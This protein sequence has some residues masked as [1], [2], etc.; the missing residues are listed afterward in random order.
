MGTATR[1]S[2][3]PFGTVLRLEAQGQREGETLTLTTQLGPTD[4]YE[5]T[6]APVVACALQLLDGSVELPGVHCQALLAEPA[7]LIADLQQMGIAVTSNLAA[8]S[9]VS[10]G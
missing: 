1:A 3:P 10:P 5:L 2:G 7:R 9:S 6:A 8:N 4:G